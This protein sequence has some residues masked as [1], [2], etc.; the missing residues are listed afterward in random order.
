MLQDK[1][2]AFMLEKHGLTD[3]DPVLALA[4]IAIDKNVILRIRVDCL[5]E[6]AQYVHA[7]RKSID[8][9]AGEGTKINFFMSRPAEIEAPSG[10]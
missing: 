10:E 1:L 3:F 7:K 2:Q 8:I 9:N 4:E 6:V 5:K